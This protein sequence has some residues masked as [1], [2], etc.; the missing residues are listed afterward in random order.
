[1]F[2]YMRF[3]NRETDIF[4]AN[5]YQTSLPF[6]GTQ[7]SNPFLNSIFSANH[8]KIR[9]I[10]VNRKILIFTPYCFSSVE[11]LLL[12]YFEYSL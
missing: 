12:S 4:Y 10:S 5:V 2:Q 6:Y 7:I 9:E 1:M 3:N 11:Y 8:K